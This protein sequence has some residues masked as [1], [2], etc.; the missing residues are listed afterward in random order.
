MT[1]FTLLT[2][3]C[4]LNVAN[5]KTGHR[6]PEFTWFIQGDTAVPTAPRHPHPHPRRLGHTHC[7]PSS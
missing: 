7:F 3:L 4:L 2:G 1:L 5:G 6:N